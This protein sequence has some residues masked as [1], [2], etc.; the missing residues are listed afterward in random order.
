MDDFNFTL[1]VDVK[2]NVLTGVYFHS[3]TFS[4]IK[5]VEIC[6]VLKFSFDCALSFNYIIN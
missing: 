1:I 5:A 4:K 2:L 3:E 6:F